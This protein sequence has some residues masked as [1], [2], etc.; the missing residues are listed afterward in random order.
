MKHWH[1]SL[2]FIFTLSGLSSCKENSKTTKA[3]IIIDAVCDSIT[4]IK[5]ECIKMDSIST[6]YEIQT[7]IVNDEIIAVDQYFCFMYRFSADGHLKRKQLGQG[8]AKNETTIGKIAGHCFSASGKFI[9]IGFQGETSIYDASGNLEKTL[10][11][12]YNN[13][14]MA[15]LKTVDCYNNPIVYTKNYENLICKEYNGQI[16]FNVDMF[17]PVYNIIDKQTEHIKNA[18][19]I[20]TVDYSHQGK[21]SLLI[22]GLPFYYHNDTKSK[23]LFTGAHFDLSNNGDIYIAHEA[24]SLVYVYDTNQELKSIYGRAAYGIQ[25]DY[26]KCNNIKDFRDNYML[27]RSSKGRYTSLEFIDET[28]ILFRTYQLSGKA[29][30]DRMQIYKEG[31]LIG[32]TSIPKGM[33]VIGY[34]SPYYY[35]QVISDEDEQSIKIYRFKL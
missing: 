6:S 7:S 9:L 32:N 16:Y 15:D 18:Y 17:T 8:H 22:K 13:R 24:D 25:Q 30:D 35:S 10:I 31:V 2:L 28:N 1:I 34:I 27:E 14:S 23:A 4:S 33:H 29:E 3:P 21:L 12:D 20:M 26:I 5:M 11:T 19:N